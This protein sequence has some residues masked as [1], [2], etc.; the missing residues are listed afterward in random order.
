MTV[1]QTL[2]WLPV[3]IP[4]ATAAALAGQLNATAPTGRRRWRRRGRRKGETPAY[5][6][7]IGLRF[8]MWAISQSNLL[9]SASNRITSAASVPLVPVQAP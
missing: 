6:S 7:G 9:R 2:A 5:L 4:V 1:R 8:S 3:T